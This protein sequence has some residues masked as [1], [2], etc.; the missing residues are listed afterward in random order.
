[1]RPSLII[2][3]GLLSGLTPFAIDLYLPSLPSIARDLGSSMEMAQLSVTLYLAV[4][5]LS[6]VFMG[7]LSDMLGRRATLGAGLLLFVI[8]ALGCALAGRMETLF[9]MRILQAIGGAAVAV[10]V[11][12]LVRDLFERDHYA[13]VI[14]LVMMIMSLA[15][16]VA[17]TIGGLVLSY[18][19]WPWVFVTLFGIGMVA[20]LLFLWVIPETLPPEHRHPSHLGQ[21][22]SNYRQLLSHRRSLGY[23]LTGAGTFAAMMTFIVASPYVYIVLYGVPIAFFGVL[24]GANVAAAMVVTAINTRLVMRLGAERL[25]R[26][27]LRVQ[28]MAALVLLALAWM[29]SPPLW[30]LLLAILLNQGMAG[31]VLGN[32][33]AAYMT[34]FPRLAGTASALSGAVR[35]GFGATI[36]SLVSL[37]HNGTANPLLLG[38]ALSGLL[39]VGSYWLLCQPE[40]APSR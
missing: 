31:M 32:A 16:L 20:G 10:T 35:F 40:P 28:M 19:D 37:G 5:A 6:Q 4:F 33:M 11:P 9:G 13:R 34:L 39:A 26:F 17:P 18:A 8:G 25:L 15:P 3:L 30:A 14:G 24:F 38:M 2:T 27:G 7:P 22:L 1:M 21:V 36:G 29:G 23:L 12:A